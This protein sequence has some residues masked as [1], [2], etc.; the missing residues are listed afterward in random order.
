MGCSH[1]LS[2]RKMP[3]AYS[4]SGSDRAESR[5]RSEQAPFLTELENNAAV[6]RA[7]ALAISGC[8]AADGVLA[9][10][11][12]DELADEGTSL[13]ERHPDLGRGMRQ[14]LAEQKLRHGSDLIHGSSPVLRFVTAGP[15]DKQLEA[16]KKLVFE[17][18]S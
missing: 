13:K 16:S 5:R 18:G 15:P 4:T 10:V 8:P 11:A 2:I 17:R 1:A 9:S 14:R 3:V 12:E 7:P 6:V